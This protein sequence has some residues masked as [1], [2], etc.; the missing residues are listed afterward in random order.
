MK[1]YHELYTDDSNTVIK[2]DELLDSIKDLSIAEQNDILESIIIKSNT[3]NDIYK[4]EIKKYRA[5]E[6]KRVLTEEKTIESILDSKECSVKKEY[7]NNKIDEY[8][9][10]IKKI[11]DLSDEDLIC[12]LN[13]LIEKDSLNKNYV[14]YI[15][16][17]IMRE[18]KSYESMYK[19]AIDS[20]D[21]ELLEEIKEIISEL[22]SKNNILMTYKN[23]DKKDKTNATNKV[24]FFETSSKRAYFIEDVEGDVEFYDSYNKLLNSIINGS[25]IGIKYFTKND[26]LNG[27]IEVRDIEG[28]TRIFFERIGY[29]TYIIINA[30]IKKEDKSSGYKNQ[31]GSRYCLYKKHKEKIFAEMNTK[32]YLENQEGYMNYIEN[33]FNKKSPK[34]ELKRGDKDE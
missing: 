7:I 10:D 34:L 13:N 8:E 16:L 12:Y 4:E 5:L 25:F 29:D 17:G 11:I 23:I 33:M 14:I 27:L 9:K 15:M 19:I 2:I 1:N 28:K 6:S 32:E 30:I 18:I 31:L 24:L 20:K 21:K 22:N 26:T 3:I